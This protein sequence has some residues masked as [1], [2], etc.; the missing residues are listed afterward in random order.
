MKIFRIL[1]V[2]LL[3]FS[4]STKNFS[5][6]IQVDDT[7]TTQQ[8]VQNVLINSPCANI[9]NFSVY[10]DPFS[11]GQQSFGYFS[12]GTSS[13][14]FAN[15]VVLSTSRV[16]QT[17]GPN[18]NLI[19]EGQTNW[20]GDSDL[21]QA[22]GF[23]SNTTYNATVLEF[24]FVPLT[25]TISFDYLFAS[26]EYQGSAPCRYSDGFA[27]LLKPAGSSAPYQ[28]LAIIPGTNSPVLVTS[29]HPQIVGNNQTN[30]CP[31]I[32]ETFFDQY[33]PNNAPINLNGQ[34]KVLT[35]TANV[36]PGT[37]YHIKLVIA[38]H[39][40]IRYDSAIFLAGGSFKIGTNL[41][42]D[43]LISN[44]NPLCQGETL[45]LNATQTG[46]IS[47][48]WFKNGNPILDTTS[49]L[50]IVTP[51]YQVTTSGT[52][53]V[54]VFINSTCTSTDEIV[55]E[56]V[57]AP[58]VF[59]TVLF[60]CDDNSDGISKYDLT[61]VKNIITGNDLQLTVINYFT[62]P[63]E[64]QNNTN[65]IVYPREFTN[66]TANQIVY[67]RIKNQFNCISVAKITLKIASTSVAAIPA[68]FCD[69]TGIQDGIIELTQAD[70]GTITTQLITGLPTGLFVTYHT[71]YDNAL[72]QTNAISLSFINST[73]FQQVV[74]AAIVNG[75][76][77]YGVVPVT[78]N[79][80]TFLPAG[81]ET[82]LISI[83]AGVP[84]TISAPSGYST[85]VWTPINP[86]NNNQISVTAA[87]TYS[88]EVTNNKGCKAIKEF[89]VEASESAKIKNIVI[90]D[91]NGNLNTVLINYSGN[92]VYEF[93]LDG[94]NFQDSPYFTDI[95][96]GQYTI[97]INDKKGCSPIQSTFFVL[98]YPTFF[99]PNGDG[100]NDIWKIK[101]IDTR[102]NSRIEL[103]DRY[104]K[105]LGN[106]DTDTGW[107][108]KFNQQ[109]LP[110]DD[111]WFVLTLENQKQING[112]FALK[113]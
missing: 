82:E 15:G 62:D 52:Y 41:G 64:A 2:L 73:P 45:Q 94:I 65:Q 87:G 17:E 60:Q 56:Y 39:E 90:D 47:Y 74:Y 21:E 5:Q 86:S 35:A 71:T 38:D 9:S 20:L 75:A 22:V 77:C 97:F 104:G 69:K 68:D 31:A 98:T 42:G 99:T 50:P 11:A 111:Y 18:D 67:A 79:I 13:F 25:S 84:K 7:Y 12:A 30:S 46:A 101:N 106:F 95:P 16:K 53:K 57:P 105:L 51:T 72:L 10:G 32:N 70:F 59:D 36:I 6:Y 34:T 4:F 102:P 63:I 23:S 110:A 76:D 81:F 26:E 112:H 43:K 44:Q 109:N 91:F 88:V 55:I 14:P 28:N 78:L 1:A 54:E 66:T 8:L 83:C 27:F 19:D 37:S 89:Q 108:G 48:K 103:F 92:G 113:R 49:G 93:S 85:Y 96:S 24:D 3:V 61:K 107:N 58:N 29:V 80:N 100:F 33:N 40:N